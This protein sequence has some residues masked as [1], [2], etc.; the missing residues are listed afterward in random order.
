MAD[1][2]VTSSIFETA[3]L[4]GLEAMKCGAALVAVYAGGNTEYSRH[5]Q[6]SLMS[7]RY[8]NRLALDI[9]R[10]IENPNLRQK[11]VEE[12]QKETE[13]WTLE[14]SVATFENICYSF[15]ENN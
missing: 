10:L 5:E 2:F 4:P 3:V 8:E 6:N 1:I 14:K 7:Y 15:M 13:L 12:G 11:F 9:I